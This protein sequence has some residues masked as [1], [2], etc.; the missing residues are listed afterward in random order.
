M[1]AVDQFAFKV[2][3]CCSSGPSSLKTTTSFSSLRRGN[4]TSCER[5]LRRFSRQNHHRCLIHNSPFHSCILTRKFSY[6]GDADVGVREFGLKMTDRVN[7]RM[8]GVPERSFRK[9]AS[10]L[11]RLGYRVGR[12]EQMETGTAAHAHC[13]YSRIALIVALPT[14]LH[15]HQL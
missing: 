9:Y 14:T 11:V 3:Q 2:T 15:T 8:A 13:P 10:G 7:M 5:P 6:E 4:S 1:H 12:V